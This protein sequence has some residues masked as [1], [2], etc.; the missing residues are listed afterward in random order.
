MKTERLGITMLTSDKQQQQQLFYGPLSGTTQV[1]RYQ[2]K[3]SP[4][5][6]PEFT[7]QPHV[8]PQVE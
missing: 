1:S 6:H 7:C 2:K 8:Y 5:R 3:H 4:T